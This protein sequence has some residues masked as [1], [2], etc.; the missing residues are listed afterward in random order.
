M[1]SRYVNVSVQ[2]A[3]PTPSM[4]T[5]TSNSPAECSPTVHSTVVVAADVTSQLTPPIRTVTAESS[6]PRLV[7]VRVMLSPGLPE[8]KIKP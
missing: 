6:V 5:M 7:P 3:Y 4:A 2:V 8:I 1:V